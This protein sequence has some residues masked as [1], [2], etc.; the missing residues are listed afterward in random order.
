MP[1]AFPTQ[2]D[3]FFCRT[4]FF[5]SVEEASVQ[6]RV[7]LWER[8]SVLLVWSGTHFFSQVR[9]GDG[10]LKF[11]RSRNC[12]VLGEFSSVNWWLHLWCVVRVL[13]L[14]ARCGLWFTEHIIWLE[15]WWTVRSVSFSFKGPW[16]TIFYFDPQ[17]S[18]TKDYTICLKV[19]LTEKT[20][21][22]TRYNRII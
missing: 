9:Y 8:I 18:S 1:S 20:N 7:A 12:D 2:F 11:G 21:R 3:N 17:L 13:I 22:S 19:Y 15:W 10:K 5:G 16:R 14:H 4:C 6:L